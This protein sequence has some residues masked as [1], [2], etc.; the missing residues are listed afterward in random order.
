MSDVPTNFNFVAWLREWWQ[1]LA[2]I[3]GGSAS[4]VA[5]ISKKV[6]Q[7]REE[8]ENTI[9]EQIKD[10]THMNDLDKAIIELR[11]CVEKLSKSNYANAENCIL[12]ESSLSGVMTY[13]GKVEKQ[14][15]Q[16]D[17]KIEQVDIKVE[18]LAGKV[19]HL[20]TLPAQLKSI[21][22]KLNLLWDFVQGNSV[23]GGNRKYDPTGLKI[24]G[25]EKDERNN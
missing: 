6:K 4:A 13:V 5:Y 10:T 16:V 25:E 3:S 15:E 18:K 14:V 1:T 11:V 7:R 2:L 23:S 17:D 21:E 20:E 8:I 12:M 22:D 9:R 19:E 24:F